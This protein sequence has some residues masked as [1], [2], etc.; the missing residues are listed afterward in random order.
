MEY[1]LVIKVKVLVTDCHKMVYNS[2][3]ITLVRGG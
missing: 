1:Q 3:T 2:F